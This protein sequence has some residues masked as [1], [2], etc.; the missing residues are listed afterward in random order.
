MQYF[1]DILSVPSMEAV[2]GPNPMRAP[3]KPLEYL[4]AET[5]SGMS[6]SNEAQE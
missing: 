3:T 6:S 2:G 1:H 5:I 4:P